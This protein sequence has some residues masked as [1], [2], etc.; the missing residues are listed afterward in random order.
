[1]D[2]PKLHFP[3]PQNSRNTDAKQ[4]RH[5]HPTPPLD[6]ACKFSY[7]KLSGLWQDRI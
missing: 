2:Q 6:V 4:M 5:F 1:M 3:P 7:M